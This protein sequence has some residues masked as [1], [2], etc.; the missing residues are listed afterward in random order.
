MSKEKLDESNPAPPWTTQSSMYD[1]TNVLG[2]V[3]KLGRAAVDFCIIPALYLKLLLGLL[4]LYIIVSH[5]T[6]S[7]SHSYLL[8]SIIVIPNPISLRVCT[9]CIHSIALAQ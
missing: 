6:C 8:L 9:V 1:T 2:P 3:A 5:I 7:D 4:Y